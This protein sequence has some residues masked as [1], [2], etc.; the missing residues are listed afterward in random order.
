ME[1]LADIAK[2]LDEELSG[3]VLADFYAR[4][5]ALNKSPA[6]QGILFQQQND[7]DSPRSGY[8]FHKGGR[9]EL[10][11]NIGFEQG[12]ESFRFGVAF[13]LQPAQGMPDP[14]AV[15]ARKV[16]R[17]NAVMSG[18][19]DYAELQMWHY[20][21]HV[22][23]PQRVPGPVSSALV[24]SGVFVFL[25][26]RVPVG[27]G[28]VTPAQVRDGARVLERLWP[29]Y[30]HVEGDAPLATVQ[31]ETRVAR[32][33]WNTHR[34][35]RPSGLGGKAKTPATFEAANGYGHE[36]WLFDWGSVSDGWKYGFIQAFG[37]RHVHAGKV[38]DLLL[39]TL[40]S[41]KGQRYWVGLIEGVE[42]LDADTANAA[43]KVAAEEGVLER[44][45][46]EV[47][48]LG[49][50]PWTIVD[51]GGLDVLNARFRPSSVTLFEPI[52]VPAGVFA[53]DRYSILQNVP[54][55]QR[56][57]LLAGAGREALVERNLKA[58]GLTRTSYARTTEV[59]LRQVQWQKLLKLSLPRDL[60]GAKV[61]VET[62]EDGHHLD[63]IV[64]A[65]GIR[66]FVEIKTHGT[67]KQV[68]RAALSQLIEYAYW[69]AASRCDV[70]MIVGPLVASAEDQ[71]YLHMLR[72]R[73]D[74]PVYYLN[75][76]DG[77]IA[78]I[79]IFWRMI[80]EASPQAT[81]VLSVP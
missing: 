9:S 21:D 28:G 57:I 40:D 39:Y 60:P 12:G 54:E 32:L 69:P 50:D 29:L 74:I 59:D 64:E 76:D 8:A 47:R 55:G 71:G 16:E 18:Q 33:S 70:L 37:A 45:R 35:Q 38:F 79:N 22:L 77:R 14:V 6:W 75:F 15:L 4:R 65:N 23:Q 68:I 26:L 81:V 41:E 7:G 42:P 36:E 46:G 62:V 49:L 20:I 10:Q 78:G 56:D 13:G 2:A 44:M 80:S 58:T 66:A 24:R 31:R 27:K 51:G 53:A 1:K 17:F 3:G 43:V 5:R 19:H 30:E 52:P 48:A 63:L 34:W 61:H 72:E 67:P 73:F 25:G 11:F